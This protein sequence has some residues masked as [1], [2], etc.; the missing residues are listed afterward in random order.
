MALT[1]GLISNGIP[2]SNRKSKNLLRSVQPS[3]IVQLKKGVTEVTMA[4]DTSSYSSFEL[5]DE[6]Q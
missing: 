5:H 3:L 1:P 2:S 4:V 6:S